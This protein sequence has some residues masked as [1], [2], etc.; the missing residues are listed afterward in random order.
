M[1]TTPKHPIKALLNFRRNPPEALL[2]TS[3]TVHTNMD[4]NPNFAGHPAPPVEMSTL[5]AANDAL[6][7]ANVA[8]QDGGKKAI[9]QRNHQRQVVV[10]LLVELAHYVE[11][12]CKDDLTIFLSSGFKAASSVKTKLLPC[13]SRSVR[14]TRAK[15]PEKCSSASCRIPAQAAMKCGGRR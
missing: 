14:L 8:A 10:K 5:K 11:A 2:E 6:A 7:A 13:P 4:N 3:T 15:R 12:N 1:T 9:A